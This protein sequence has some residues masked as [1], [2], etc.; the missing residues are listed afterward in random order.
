[1]T[2][3]ENRTSC[4]NSIDKAQQIRVKKK[5]GQ[6]HNNTMSGCIN[7]EPCQIDSSKNKINFKGYKLSETSKNNNITRNKDVKSRQY[8]EFFTFKLLQKI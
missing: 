6:Y 8:L 7:T 1:M 3:K 2:T 4:R 5:W